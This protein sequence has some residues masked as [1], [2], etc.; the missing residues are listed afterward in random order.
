M[1]NKTT[2]K[3]YKNIVLI[4]FRGCGKS[5][6]GKKLSQKTSY[7]FVD[8]DD[9]I[10]SKT[11]KTI[12]E[13]IQDDNGWEKFRILETNTL[14]RLLGFQKQIIALGGGFGVNDVIITNNKIKSLNQISDKVKFENYGQLQSFILQQKPENFKIYLK[15]TEIEILERL[16]KIYKEKE[17]T[18]Q[19]PNLSDLKKFEF[20]PEINSWFENNTDQGS[21]SDLIFKL[22][23]DLH[24]FLNR[25]EKYEKIA[26]LVI[27]NKPQDIQKLCQK[28]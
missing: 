8:L 27:Q 2:N 14:L 25:K 10:E 5:T 21:E 18:W 15:L 4:G 6:I 16:L 26:D 19:R 12:Q 22:K 24:N 11:N 7:K 17:K 3:K 9:E 28:L 23:N 13:I 1:L 20:E